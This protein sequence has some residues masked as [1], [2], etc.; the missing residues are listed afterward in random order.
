MHG[1]WPQ[2]GRGILQ[3]PVAIML[4]VSHPHLFCIRV[5]AFDWSRDG[6]NGTGLRVCLV[7]VSQLAQ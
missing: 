1:L 5:T 2:C 7:A 4:E 3:A 6:C